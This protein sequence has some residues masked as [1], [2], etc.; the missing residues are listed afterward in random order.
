MQKSIYHLKVMKSPLKL[1][2]AIQWSDQ[3]TYSEEPKCKRF[4]DQSSAI[5]F[6]D[7]M[8]YD[9]FVSGLMV[10]CQVFPVVDV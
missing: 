6:T 9:D 8:P 1:G 2:Y 10:H 4:P 7:P 3:F 5:G